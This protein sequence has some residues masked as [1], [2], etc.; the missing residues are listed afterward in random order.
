MWDFG[1]RPPEAIEPV[2]DI[3]LEGAREVTSVAILG[4]QGKEPGQ[5]TDPRN[6]AIGPDGGYMCWIQVTI[7]YKFSTPAAT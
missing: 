1:A 5:F 4:M 2:R 3:Y 7:G 6:V